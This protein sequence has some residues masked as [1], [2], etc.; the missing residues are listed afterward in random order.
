MP[1]VH[2]AHLLRARLNQRLV[3][4]TQYPIAL[5]LAPAGFGKSVAL[6]DFLFATRLDAVRLEVRREENTFLA[7]TRRFCEVLAPIAPSITASFP[8]MQERALS[9]SDPP[10]LT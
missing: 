6:R 4:A 1:I 3:R 10:R 7:F 5:I 2:D 8:A 9:A